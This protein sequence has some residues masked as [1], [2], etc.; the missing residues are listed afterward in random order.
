MC[1][2]LKL[3]LLTRVTRNSDPETLNIP[4]ETPKLNIS[5]EYFYFYSQHIS[6][7]VFVTVEQ[8]CLAGETAL[9]DC[10]KDLNA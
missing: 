1:Q 8:S 10:D 4:D 5:I 9:L 6:I 7:H 2:P 3:K